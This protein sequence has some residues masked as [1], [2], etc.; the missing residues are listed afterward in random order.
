MVQKAQ[1]L[2][3]IPDAPVINLVPV[4]VVRA[5]SRRGGSDIRDHWGSIKGFIHLQHQLPS[6]VDLHTQYGCAVCF[7]YFQYCRAGGVIRILDC[8][9]LR[10]P[11]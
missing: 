2:H 6:L 11:F 7:L 1:A 5:I 4:C 9:A 3:L 8:A 10:W